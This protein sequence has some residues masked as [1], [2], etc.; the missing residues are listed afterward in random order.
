M[1]SLTDA[2]TPRR[3]GDRYQFDVLPGWQQGRGAFGGLVIGALVR[4]IEDHT[5]EPARKLRSLTAELP[6]PAM[7]GTVEIAVDTLRQ[8][9]NLS[10][11]RAALIQ[12]GEVKSHAVAILAATRTGGPP[13]AWNDL[14][15]PVLP[16]WQDVAPIVFAQ[17]PHFAQHFEHRVVEAA[18]TSTSGPGGAPRS[19]GWIRPKDAG[20]AR[21]AAYIAAMAD[22]WWP[23]A[24]V[25]L[26]GRPMATIAY[27]LEIVG[28]VDGLDP[29]APLIYR[30]VVP[31]CA[32]G[33]FVETRELW[34][35]DGRLIAINHQ[36]FAV[37]Q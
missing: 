29:A 9:K 25:R 13:V 5:A 7:T 6:G 1:A 31:V 33:Y 2:L 26:A 3:S 17:P 8:G 27:T 34:G 20:A 32:D 28:S 10:A 37:I 15:P 12:D 36:T 14:T 22:A 16:R 19:L 21:D 30:A 18:S 11:V 35:E 24:A 4:A 23:A